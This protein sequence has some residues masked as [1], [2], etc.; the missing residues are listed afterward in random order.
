M[1][2]SCYCFS[3]QISGMCLLIEFDSHR[4]NL[5]ASRVVKEG[6]LW[7]AYGSPFSASWTNT[8]MGPVAAGIKVIFHMSKHEQAKAKSG[9]IPHVGSQMIHLSAI[10]LMEL[11]RVGRECSQKCFPA[12]METLLI[13]F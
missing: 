4:Q 13:S 11:G 10:D 1:E 2:I 12:E 6:N 9:H 3:S 7:M 5:R 8:D